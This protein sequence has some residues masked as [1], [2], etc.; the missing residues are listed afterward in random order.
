MSTLVQG[1]P[2]FLFAKALSRWF[3]RSSALRST[4]CTDA[5]V[6]RESVLRRPR[7][8]R[9]SQLVPHRSGQGPLVS[10]PK[11]DTWQALQQSI[12]NAAVGRMLGEQARAS[13]EGVTPVS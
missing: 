11:T 12:G 10:S 1:Q 2:S 4:L 13:G 9:E 8:S 3:D 5:G 6:P 7:S